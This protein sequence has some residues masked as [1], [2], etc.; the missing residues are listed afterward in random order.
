MYADEVTNHLQ[1]NLLDPLLS[2][3]IGYSKSYLLHVAIDRKK[4]RADSQGSALSGTLHYSIASL[5]PQP[6][7]GE[8]SREACIYT[9]K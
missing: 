8:T 2:F 4:W 1:R 6:L 5:L 7:V 3:F 9:G